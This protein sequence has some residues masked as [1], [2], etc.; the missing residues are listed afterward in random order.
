[1]FDAAYPGVPFEARVAPWVQL[2]LGCVV[3]PFAMI[4]RLPSQ[5]PA[6]ARKGQ[7]NRWLI[8]GAGTEVG[9]GAIIYGGVKIGAD[10]LIGDQASVREGATIGDRCI[11]GHGVSIN[12]DAR[13]A[14]E[15]RINTGSHVT[16]GAVIGRGTFIG[17][18]VVMANDRR[19]EIVDYE[20]V[21]V[22][23]PVIGERC[24]I[25]SGAM[26]MPGVRIGDGAVI[27]GGALVVKDVPP[28]ATVLAS[29]AGLR[30]PAEALPVW[31]FNEGGYGAERGA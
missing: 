28:G 9:V 5:S 3:H 31:D 22:D 2:G 11:V 14:D 23:P 29:P 7:V 26:I 8:I 18:G 16:G 20:F 24:L 15:V 17:V 12:Y 27:G 25:G 10:C 4:G 6:L 30:K 1:M 13:I 19:R 21:G